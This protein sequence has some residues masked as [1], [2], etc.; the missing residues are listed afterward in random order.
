MRWPLCYQVLQATKKF[1]SQ[2]APLKRFAG[3]DFLC[4]DY[5]LAV[6]NLQSAKALLVEGVLATCLREITANPK[7]MNKQYKEAI[8]DH[9]GDISASVVPE[10]L[11]HPVL[12]K[13]ARSAIQTAAR[14]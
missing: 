5:P 4:N 8:R 1:A 11:V 14:T 7:N 2:V 9:L 10:E 13:E 3:S 6:K 12:L